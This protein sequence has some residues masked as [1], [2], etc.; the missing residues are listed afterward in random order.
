MVKIRSHTIL[1]LIITCFL[2][3]LTMSHSQTAPIQPNYRFEP[4]AL[5]GGELGN[6]VQAIAQDSFGFMWFGSQFGLHRWDGYQL[7]TY[8]HQAD[9]PQSLA[10]NYVEC[11]YVSSD[12]TLWIGHWGSSLDRF[13][14]ATETFEHFE[15]TDDY[16]MGLG[17]NYI[18]TM[19]ED[20]NQQLWLGTHYGVYRFDPR[21]GQSRQFLH[22]PTNPNSLSDNKCRVIYQDSEG[23][24]WFG[25][26]FPW[27]QNESGGLNRY[28]P[29][30]GDFERYL[31]QPGDPSSLIDNKVTSILEDSRGNF[32]V[33]TRKEG[34]HQMDRKTGTFRRLMEDPTMPN[35]VRANRE[36]GKTYDRQ[37][38]FIFEDQDQKIWVGAYQG[39]ISYYDPETGYLQDYFHEWDNPQTLPEDYAWTLYQSKDGTLWGSTSGPNSSVFRLRKNNFEFFSGPEHA[40]S[41]RTF[42]QTADNQLWF[43]TKLHGIARFNPRTGERTAYPVTEI[44]SVEWIPEPPPSPP[45]VKELLN[46]IVEMEGDSEGTLWMRHAFV[47]GLLRFFPEEGKLQ[48]FCAS[49][50]TKGLGVGNITDL[51][52][53]AGTIWAVGAQGGL[54]RFDRDSNNFHRYTYARWGAEDPQRGY[55]AQLAASGDQQIWLAASA[56]KKDHLPYLLLRFNVE[57]GDF[58][59]LEPQVL[60][61]DTNVQY[62]PIY[63]LAEDR[64]GGLWVCSRTRLR[65][66]ATDG[67]GSMYFPAVQFGSLEFRGMTIDDRNRLWVFGDRAILIDPY[68]GIN[69]SF[70]AGYTYLKSMPINQ[71]AVFKDSE[72]V[73]YFGGATGLQRLYPERI[74]NSPPTTLLHSIQ[75]LYSDQCDLSIP[76]G[77]SLLNVPSLQLTY[78]QNAFSLRFAAL[79]FEVPE[80]NR[81][82]FMLENYDE[83]WRNAGVDPVVTYVKVPPGDYVFRVR[84]ATQGSSWGPEVQ[85]PIRIAPP[86]WSSWWAYLLY[87]LV[88]LGVLYMFYYLQRRRIEHQ[89]EAQRLKEVDSLKTRLY[90]NITHEF[91]TP[92]TVISG[93]ASQLREQPQQ[94]LERGVPL[95]ERNSQRLLELVNQMLDLSKLESGKMTLQ[96]YQAD[97]IRFLKFICNNLHS[98]AERQDVELHFYAEESDIIMDFDREKMQQ[99]ISNLLSNAVKFSP[100][101]GH[102]YLTVRQPSKSEVQLRVRD[103]GPGI[104][105][106]EL[107]RIFDRFYQVDDSNTRQAEGSGIGLALVKELVR[108]MEGRI[109]V[110]STVGEGTTFILCLPVRRTAEPEPA[111]RALPQVIAASVGD[112][113]LPEQPM[114][115]A[116][117]VNSDRPEIL[118]IE[119]NADVVAYLVSCL[120]PSY[121]ILVGTDGQEGIEIAQDRIPDLIITDVMMPRKDGF[122]VCRSLKADQRTSHIPIIML[123]ARADQ[124]SK[125]SGLEEGVDAYLAKPFHR[126]ELLIRIR[127]LLE[128]R[129]QL[130]AYF[131]AAA[132]LG[133]GTQ[134]LRE[135]PEPERADNQFVQQVRKVVEEHL[136]D[137]EFT[138][139]ALSRAVALSTSQ[140]H[141]KLSALTGYSPQKFIRYIRLQRAQ[142]LL[143]TTDWSITAIALESGFN[144]PNYFGRVFRKELGCAPSEWRERVLSGT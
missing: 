104:P 19:F 79:D 89:S 3:G 130:Q 103:T 46:G 33:G 102:V 47:P 50:T 108:L 64:D 114:N 71:K 49:S 14:Y 101:G 107:P 94:W 131:L 144:D 122:E 22:N 142:E 8:L 83:D 6:H 63:G 40:A 60:V 123:T 36:L 105:E 106:S 141:R 127:K 78:D 91:R 82:Q 61:D 120:E 139:E 41:I 56:S 85:L 99:L 43:G 111:D 126:D 72:G 53:H 24:L 80:G 116:G 73:I 54:Y 44:K 109:E 143:Q 75:W 62:E 25:T 140:L 4:F 90:T 48:I 117:L 10:S 52:H 31:H 67:S 134:F 110:N 84:G 133:K 16:H 74:Q 92:L 135:A 96:L 1:L 57:T 97:L 137:Y 128:S 11:I 30:S 9:D 21:T 37:I 34:L 132:G 35:P 76:S 98:M 20:E 81:H 118:L 125:L 69:S 32:W 65:R 121:R 138:V 23:T 70:G 38:R 136:D 77:A 2:S 29:E 95:I 7:K 100:A 86:W 129:Q 112:Q 58:K 28:R 113:V 45:S 115:S 66:L 13:D 59:R 26:G 5:P 15:F 68:A 119:D 27:G 55:I 88:V 17:A 18:V 93:M 124:A 42:G 39:G 51:L 87:G 12:S